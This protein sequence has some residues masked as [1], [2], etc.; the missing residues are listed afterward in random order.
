MRVKSRLAAP[1]VGCIPLFC[2]TKKKP[3]RRT[4]RAEANP[5]SRKIVFIY[6]APSLSHQCDGSRGRGHSSR[7]GIPLG[8]YSPR[9]AA[10][11]GRGTR[12]K[13]GGDSGPDIGSRASLE[14]KYGESELAHVSVYI[15]YI[16]V[17]KKE[18]EEEERRSGPFHSEAYN[19]S[20]AVCPASRSAATFCP[21]PRQKAKIH[22]ERS[23]DVD[24]E[25]KGSG[26]RPQCRIKIYLVL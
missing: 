16:R 1:T 11:G 15:I 24:G 3:E 25:E 26:R 17:K 23:D 7:D 5:R 19:S 14:S 13:G 22:T 10:G 2:R 9:R 8:I 6:S 18:G 20:S 21:G 12:E 4:R